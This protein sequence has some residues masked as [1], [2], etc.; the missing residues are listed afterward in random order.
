M[1]KSWTAENVEIAQRDVSDLTL[2]TSITLCHSDVCQPLKGT[3]ATQKKNLETLTEAYNTCRNVILF[4]SVN[5]SRAFQ[6]Y[7]SRILSPTRS[8]FKCCC[9]IALI[10]LAMLQEKPAS[11]I[12]SLAPSIIAQNVSYT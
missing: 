11:A 3:W 5:N 2:T 1:I 4:F 9:P 8:P 7:V 6:G 10:C 12:L